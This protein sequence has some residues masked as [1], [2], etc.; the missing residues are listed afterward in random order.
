MQQ[1]GQRFTMKPNLKANALAAIKSSA[2]KRAHSADATHEHRSFAETMSKLETLE[3]ALEAWGW[4][5]MDSGDGTSWLECLGDALCDDRLLFESIA[6]FVE[7]GSFIEMSGE[8]GTLWR[9][10]FDGKQC[11]EQ[12]GHVV[13]GESARVLITVRGGVADY[14]TDGNVKVALID[15]DNDLDPSQA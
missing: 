15:Y 8:D 5:L 12:L 13:F 2:M 1:C 14:V 6:P 10:Y 11:E 3:Q 4:Q 7:A 9:W